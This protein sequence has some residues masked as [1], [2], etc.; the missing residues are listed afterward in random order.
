MPAEAKCL[1]RNRLPLNQP[2]EIQENIY[3]SLSGI[4]Y[5]PARDAAAGLMEHGI[6]ALISWGVAGALEPSL[7]TGDVLIPDL[8]IMEHEHFSPSSRW[9]DNIKAHL[10][11][12]LPNIKSGGICTTTEI[13]AATENKQNLLHKTGAQAVEMESAAIAKLACEKNIDFIAVKAISDEADTAIP[14]A[15]LSGID[16]A[17]TL[18]LLSFLN[19]CCRRPGQVLQIIKTASDYKKALNTLKKIAVDLKKH[20]FLY[21]TRTDF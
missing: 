11:K 4:G 5:R 8:I 15:V 13:C 9:T 1:Y 20:H 14:D 3:L 7:I 10:A 18:D 12:T 21:N 6:D 16:N 19:S 17:G 2:T